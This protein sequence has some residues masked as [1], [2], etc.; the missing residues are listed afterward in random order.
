MVLVNLP[1]KLG[2]FVWANVGDLFQHHG[3]WG[4]VRWGEFSPAV[5]VFMG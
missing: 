3:A 5:F 2:D 1:T 4:I